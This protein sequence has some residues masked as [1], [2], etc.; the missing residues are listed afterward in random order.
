MFPPAGRTRTCDTVDP[1]EV[2]DLFTTGAAKGL[3][4]N[5]REWYG[6]AWRRVS[7][8]RS[9][10]RGS[11]RGAASTIRHAR[12]GQLQNGAVW[13]EGSILFT[14]GKSVSG[15]QDA[16]AFFVTKES[17]ASPPEFSKLSSCFR[18][19]NSVKG[20][21][22][23]P[24]R[25]MGSGGVR[26]RTF[27]GQAFRPPRLPETARVDLHTRMER[28]SPANPSQDKSVY[29]SSSKSHLAGTPPARRRDMLRR[30]GIVNTPV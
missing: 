27:Y 12:R 13:S 1:N 2:T 18:C 24:L 4:G 23:K 19:G 16:A 15:E 9:S 6:L 22:Q 11:L 21:K 29:G 8:T 17:A 28:H 7:S 10:R 5:G 26:H 20:R 25:S 3:P 30:R 14:T